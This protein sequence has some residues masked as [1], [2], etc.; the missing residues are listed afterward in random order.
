MGSVLHPYIVEAVRVAVEQQTSRRMGEAKLLPHTFCALKFLISAAK[1]GHTVNYEQISLR[2]GMGNAQ[3]A[4]IT[5]HPIYLLTRRVEFDPQ[6]PYDNVPDLTAIVSQKGKTSTG[7]G[8]FANH[9]EM[10]G[11]SK[12]ERAELLQSE[13]VRALSW[14]HWAEFSAFLDITPLPVLAPPREDLIAFDHAS[15]GPGGKSP[16]HQTMQ[17]RIL[18]NPIC[19]GVNLKGEILRDECECEY[20]FWSQDRLDVVIK[21]T[22]EWVGFEVKPLSASENELRKGIYQV[23]KYAALMR[24]DLLDRGKVKSSRC[25]LVIQGYLTTTLTDL[26]RTLGVQFKE[27]FRVE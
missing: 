2:C 27:G 25:V 11:K 1:R 13:R 7:H 6:F 23:V 17:D 16:E 22:K 20:L 3:W 10:E 24:A 18:A 5:F 26:A 8:F 14:R 19:V 12:A 9:P 15:R 4:N 21:T